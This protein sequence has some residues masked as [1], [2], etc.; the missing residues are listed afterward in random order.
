M[1]AARACD[2]CGRCDRDSIAV[3][4]TLDGLLVLTARLCAVHADEV[5]EAVKDVIVA[6][7]GERGAKRPRRDRAFAR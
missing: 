7:E 2:A 1:R 3:G 4:V 5:R 6:A